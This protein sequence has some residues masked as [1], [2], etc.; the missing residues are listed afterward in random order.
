MEAEE[1]ALQGIEAPV[2]QP[3]QNLPVIRP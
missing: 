3:S 1:G 2:G